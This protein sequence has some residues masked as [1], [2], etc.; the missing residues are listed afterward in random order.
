MNRFS[1]GL[2]AMIL[3]LAAGVSAQTTDWKGFYVGGNAGGVKGSADTFTSTVFSPT[4]YFAMSS[5]PAIAAVGKQKL[6]PRGFTGGGQ[7][8]YNFQTGHFVLGLETDFGAM[9]VNDDFVGSTTYPCCAPTNFTVK[10]SIST[11]WLW[12][13]R[14]RVGVAAGP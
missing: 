8:G 12:T 3:A 9:H 14:P 13:A 1:T 10:Q 11:D 5:V 2:C 7:V 6:S 4:G